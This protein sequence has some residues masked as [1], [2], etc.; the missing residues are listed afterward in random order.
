VLRYTAG[1]GDRGL[2]QVKGVTLPFGTTEFGGHASAASRAISDAPT[3]TNLNMHVCVQMEVEV[4]G[5][6]SVRW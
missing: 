5:G 6:G 3:A 2:E 4:G 1:D